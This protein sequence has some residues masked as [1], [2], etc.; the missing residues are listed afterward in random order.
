MELLSKT[1]LSI[2]GLIFALLILESGDD[3]LEQH[4]RQPLSAGSREPRF[5]ERVNAAFLTFM[6]RS[7]SI[8]C[9]LTIFMSGQ[10]LLRDLRPTLEPRSSPG[11]FISQ[12]Y[13][14][15]TSA[16]LL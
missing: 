8:V 15:A 3:G 5:N 11:F 7:S 13:S 10:T 9:Y 12:A 14:G 6:K 4:D 1:Q 2:F 16:H